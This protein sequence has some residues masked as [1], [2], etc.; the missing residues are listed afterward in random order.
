MGAGAS[1]NALPVITNLNERIF[2]FKNYIEEL[3]HKLKP[4]INS[5]Q[6]G[7]IDEIINHFKFTLQYSSKFKSIDTLAFCF[8]RD[9]TR[10]NDYNQLKKA[11]ITYFSLEQILTDIPGKISYSQL[12]HRYQSLIAYH[13]QQNIN[14]NAY[15]SPLHIITWNYDM[16]VDL[17]LSLFDSNHSINEIKEK[18]NIYPNKSS[19]N[20]TIKIDYDESDFNI[21][22]LNGNAFIDTSLNNGGK[23][24]SF[25]G[26]L[27]NY[28]NEQKMINFLTH[29]DNEFTNGG[30]SGKD[31][32]KYF[33]F[34]W[35]TNEN[36]SIYTGRKFIIEHAIKMI[37]D[38]KNIIVVGYSFPAINR[39]IDLKL[40]ENI[41]CEKIYIQDQYPE[42]IILNLKDMLL[43]LK[44]WVPNFKIPD[45]I[46]IGGTHQFYI[47]Y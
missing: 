46:D 25:D 29:Y 5:G 7:R 43:N 30:S 1:A 24:S 35:E 4:E 9:K 2:E 44:A 41:R 40:F 13:L 36:N 10:I 33:N 16:Q 18:Y 19:Y 27:H 6:S 32:H 37:A 42:K 39:I 11:L 22:K 17:T 23:T 12:D 26:N 8:F 14:T 45:I 38:A 3:L 47:P 20:S 31:S 21:I 34:S 28:S 15:E